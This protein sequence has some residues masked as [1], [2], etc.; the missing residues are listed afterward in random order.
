[1][2]GR[3]S[4]S[5]REVS[6]SA[7]RT[8]P[9]PMDTCFLWFSL[10]GTGSR[11]CVSVPCGAR[12]GLPRPRVGGISAGGG[13]VPRVGGISA[14]GRVVVISLILLILLCPKSSLESSEFGSGVVLIKYSPTR[15]V[16]LSTRMGPVGGGSP[17]VAGGLL[18]SSLLSAIPLS[19]FSF[20]LIQLCGGA[21]SP[22]DPTSVS[23]ESGLVVCNAV[24]MCFLL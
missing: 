1:M 2:V 19:L 15:E 16:E 13:F 24:F 18:M 12:G 17:I 11:P 6:V 7:E 20:I 21:E 23:R 9:S 14:G 4:S 22:A 8:E 3:C 5:P 10:L